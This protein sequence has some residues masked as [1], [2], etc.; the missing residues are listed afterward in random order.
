MP[1]VRSRS[2]CFTYNNPTHTYEEFR[3]ALMALPFVRYFVYQRE[4]GE[5]GT[6]HY[7]GY[8]EFSKTVTWTGLR[9]I[10][11]M[12]VELRRGSRSQARDYCMTDDKAG[13]Q[14]AE[15]LEWGRWEL[16]PGR[17]S[18]LAEAAQAVLDGT[19]LAEIAREHPATFVRNYRGLGVL[20]LFRPNDTRTPPCVTLL[21]GPSGCGKSGLV[22]QTQDPDVLYCKPGDDKWWDGYDRH[23]RVLLDDFAGAASKISLTLCLTWLDRYPVRVPVKGGYARLVAEH[24]Y[25][26]SNI[27]PKKWYDYSNRQTQYKALARRI[28]QVISFVGEYRPVL[29]DHE[30][31]FSLP[32][33]PTILDDGMPVPESIVMQAGPVFL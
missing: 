29:L 27:H 19:S 3:D 14:L 4:R 33:G 7:Q 17:R 12:H 15:P 24:I 32:L 1:V 26:T 8:I 22:H 21:W 13:E 5:S 2:F 20:A 31:F 6:E 18:D 28:H 25:I 30:K 11:P 23:Q 16:A 9:A 10:A